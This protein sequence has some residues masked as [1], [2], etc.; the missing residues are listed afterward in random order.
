MQYLADLECPFTQDAAS[1]TSKEVMDWLLHYAVDLAYGD[2]GNL[3]PMHLA[4][5]HHPLSL[6]NLVMYVDVPL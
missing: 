4:I 1:G 5:S 2:H 3:Q 6:Y